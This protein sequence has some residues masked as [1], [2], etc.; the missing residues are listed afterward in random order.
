MNIL[1]DARDLGFR[2]RSTN[3]EPYINTVCYS[4]GVTAQCPIG[5]S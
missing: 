3:C 5:E 4:K 1:F 2:P